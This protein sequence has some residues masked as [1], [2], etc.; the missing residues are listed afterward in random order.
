MPREVRFA[1]FRIGAQ[2]NG[3]ALAGANVD[4]QIDHVTGKDV[5][6][7]AQWDA[8]RRTNV[9]LSEDREVHWSTATRKT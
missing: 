5:G 4:L 1:V 3:R 7:A 2:A 9:L 8:W 6:N